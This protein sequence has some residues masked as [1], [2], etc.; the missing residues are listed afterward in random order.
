M[1]ETMKQYSEHGRCKGPNKAFL[2]E[3]QPALISEMLELFA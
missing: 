2:I 1:V 3:V